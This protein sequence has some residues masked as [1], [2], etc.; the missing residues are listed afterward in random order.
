[1][2]NSNTFSKR[3]DVLRLGGAG[4][5]GLTLGA[6]TLEHKRKMLGPAN[7]SPWWCRS[8]QEVAP[9]HLRVLSRLSLSNK[10][11]RPW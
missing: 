11:A 3:R 6:F 2:K 8:L 5:A 9:M 7:L 1:M 4:V 10:P